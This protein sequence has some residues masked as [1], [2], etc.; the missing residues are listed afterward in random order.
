MFTVDDLISK[1]DNHFNLIALLDSSNTKTFTGTVDEF[2]ASELYLK[3]AHAKVTEIFSEDNGTIW[4]CY[5]DEES[6]TIEDISV[7]CIEDYTL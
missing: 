1:M 3:I 5:C 2:R 7:V 6:N 4:I